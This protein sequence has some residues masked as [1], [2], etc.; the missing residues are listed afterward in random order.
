MSSSPRYWAVIPAAGV[1]RRM[2][3]DK[4][5]QYLELSGRT[6]L[7]HTIECFYQHPLIKVV[8]VV[9]SND[10]PHWP[11]LEI[12]KHTKIHTASGG[13]ER[14]H[15][16]LNGL[17]ALLD[18]ADD[19][20][21]ILVHDAARPCIDK[22]DIDHFIQQIGDHPI[23]GI[24]ATPVRDTMKRSNDQ[25]EIVDTV[26]R[27]QLWHALTPQMFRFKALRSALIS[28]LDTEQTVTDEAQAIELTSVKPLLISA[29]SYTNKITHMGDLAIAEQYLLQRGKG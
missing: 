11:E 16:V 1:G 6:I 28:V 20:D 24:L 15:S 4:P 9:I 23:G 25:N 14:C 29:R 8:V 12:S 18:I 2:S 10:D 7:E 21:W 13:I 3:A 26:E 5:K 22:Q 27:E 19:D 17:N